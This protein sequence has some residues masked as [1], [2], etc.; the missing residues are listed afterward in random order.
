M[1]K[2]TSFDDSEKIKI[3]DWAKEYVLNPTNS[4][5]EKIV[6]EV[7]TYLQDIIKP[8][9]FNAEHDRILS[10]I[11]KVN[12]TIRYIY[13]MSTTAKPGMWQ[14]IVDPNPAAEKK[15][16]RWATSF[17]GDKYDVT[18][19]SEMSKSFLAQLPIKN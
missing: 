13:T 9:N 6:K 2:D 4:T 18:G 15:G 16:P 17:P 7:D 3:I 14:F 10:E 5:D 12:P 1:T 11:K 8:K 19:F